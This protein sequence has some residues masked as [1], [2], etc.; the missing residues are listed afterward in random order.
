M[1]PQF[2]YMYTAVDDKYL[3]SRQTKSR[4]TIELSRI[5]N[6]YPWKFSSEI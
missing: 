5:V 4:K 2:S 1:K 6:L 3:K